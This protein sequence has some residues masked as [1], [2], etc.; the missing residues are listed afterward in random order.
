[1]R[2]DVLIVSGPLHSRDRA[3][4]I[5]FYLAHMLDIFSDKQWIDACVEFEA[6]SG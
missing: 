1:M 4:N 2:I 5:V 3:A 6:P